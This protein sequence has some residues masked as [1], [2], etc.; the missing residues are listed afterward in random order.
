[1]PF[2]MFFWGGLL[3]FV[4]EPDWGISSHGSL[5]PLH[6]NLKLAD[7]K[8]D[9]TAKSSTASDWAELAADRVAGPNGAARHSM[10]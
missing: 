6:V 5:S 7:C 2:H 8:L 1:M 4:G 3:E 9:P 10:E